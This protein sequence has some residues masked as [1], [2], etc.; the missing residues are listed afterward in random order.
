VLVKGAA[1]SSRY[2]DPGSCGQPVKRQ[3]SILK[4]VQLN[5]RALRARVPIGARCARQTQQSLSPSRPP[6]SPPRE[7]AISAPILTEIRVA[8]GSAGQSCA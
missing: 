2:R 3:P 6:N 5:G 1:G 4:P 8:S 7:L